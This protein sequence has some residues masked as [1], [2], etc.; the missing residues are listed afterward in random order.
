MKKNGLPVVPGS[1][2]YLENKNALPKDSLVPLD[3]YMC[4]NL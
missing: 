1:E 3:L 2:K 4:K